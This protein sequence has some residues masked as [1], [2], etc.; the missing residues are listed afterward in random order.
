MNE[1]LHLNAVSCYETRDWNNNI[2]NIFFG[3]YLSCINSEQYNIAKSYM[4]VA[5][6]RF[7]GSALLNN[8]QIIFFC[9]NEF[10][11]RCEMLEYY[12]QRLCLG[13]NRMYNILIISWQKGTNRCT[14]SWWYRSTYVS[15]NFLDKNYVNTTV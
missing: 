10:H 9:K 6:N 2:H 7:L 8:F 3:T 5:F 12:S 13:L 11:I 4:D 1:F 15:L 14:R